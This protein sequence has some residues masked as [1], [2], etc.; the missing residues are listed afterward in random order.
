MSSRSSPPPLSPPLRRGGGLGSLA[1]RSGRGGGEGAPPVRLVVTDIDGCLGAAEGVPFDLEVLARI[2]DWNRRAQR[3][4]PVPAITLC[5]GRPAPYVDAMV[6]AIGGFVPAVCENGAGLYFPQEYRFA[7]HP[8]L[9]AGAASIVRRARDLIEAAVVQAGIGYFQPGKERAITLLASPGHALAEVGSACEAAL[10]GHG[11]PVWVEV[12]V[13]TVGI[14]LEGSDKGAG[15]EWLAAET[16]IPVSAMAG[17]G[18][19]EGDLCFLMRTGFSA[20][21]ANAEEAVKARVDYV[22]AHAYGGGLIDI[23]EHVRNRE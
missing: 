14:W 19:A 18:D 10:A 7:W 3:G 23:I 5:S 8:G 12:S 22:S 16:C 15:L 2:A 4:E 1:R 9:P 13:T 17:V 20:A 6:Q 21:P 11:L